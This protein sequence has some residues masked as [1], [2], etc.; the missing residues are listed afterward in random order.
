MTLI[1][2]NVKDQ[3]SWKLHSTE[4]LSPR[5]SD[6]T[7]AENF[8]QCESYIVL[9]KIANAPNALIQFGDT[10]R[11]NLEIDGLQKLTSAMKGPLC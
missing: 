8:E 2:R 3:L 5:I 4:K 6:Q 10:Q 7:S 1:I 9:D 11:T